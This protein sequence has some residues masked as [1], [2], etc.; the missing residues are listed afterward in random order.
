MK[1]VI[2]SAVLLLFA[3][4]MSAQ[5]PTTTWPYLYPEFREGTAYLKDRTQSVQQYNIHIR[6]DRLHFIDKQGII[7]ETVP[8]DI[9]MVEIGGDAY[10]NVDGEMMKVVAKT[11]KGFV[12]AE[13]LGDFAALL[14]TGGAYGTSST[15]SATQKL[16]SI[17]T[18]NQINQSYMLIQQNKSNGAMVDLV[19]KLF[20]VGPSFRIPAT[21]KEVESL[22]PEDR[23][24]DWKAWQKANKVKWNKPESLAGVVEFLTNL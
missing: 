6:H 4:A 19:T 16:S 12:A 21:K 5:E 24:A 1:K 11:E 9:V 22:I 13:I 15:T 7:R 2:I 8:G 10:Y 17:D 20:L 23:K 14:E 18:N 3:W